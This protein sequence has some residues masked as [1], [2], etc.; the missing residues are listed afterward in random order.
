MDLTFFITPIASIIVGFGGAIFGAR[1]A[2]G[3]WQRDQARTR[4]SVLS[5]YERALNDMSVHLEGIA[6][7]DLGG[8]PKP[9]DLE[10]ARK[11]AHEYLGELPKEER[12]MVMYPYDVYAVHPMEE[13]AHFAK[14]A[15][16]IT[17]ILHDQPA[18]NR[19]GF[20]RWWS[21]AMKK[22]VIPKESNG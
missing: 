18:S 3:V 19:K 20:R 17:R 15:S 2:H 12:N 7:P 10:D 4:R 14:L 5:N 6:I 1:Q 16:I 8:H 13:S 11:A 21:R 22:L 9:D